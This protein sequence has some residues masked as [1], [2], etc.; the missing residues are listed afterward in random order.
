FDDLIARSQPPHPPRP[1]LAPGAPCLRSLGRRLDVGPPFPEV[2]DGLL[3]QPEYGKNIEILQQSQMR[4]RTKA[5]VCPHD[6]TRTQRVLNAL[7]LRQI[8]T[9]RRARISRWRLS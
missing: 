3:M 6:I 7:S 2:D 1:G 8:V 9:A 4:V 5:A